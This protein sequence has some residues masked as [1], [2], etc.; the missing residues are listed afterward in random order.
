MTPD[1]STRTR[2][3]L[4]A[5]TGCEHGRVRNAPLFRWRGIRWIWQPAPAGVRRLGRWE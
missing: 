4:E 5:L 2:V 3:P 1:W